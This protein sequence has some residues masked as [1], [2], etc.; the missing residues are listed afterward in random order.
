MSLQKK[1][2]RSA[3]SK[4]V[5]V[6]LEQEEHMELDDVVIDDDDKE[7]DQSASDGSDGENTKAKKKKEGMC[8]VAPRV[9]LFTTVFSHMFL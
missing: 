3:R 7:E 4:A 9:L 8:G 1:T 2:V 5:A 6:A